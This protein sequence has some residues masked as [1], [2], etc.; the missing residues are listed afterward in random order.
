MVRGVG[1]KD[2]AELT[3]VSKPTVL[4]L[5][6]DL[7]RA[8]L[9]DQEVR[10]RD[11]PC[12]VIEADEI[13][14]YVK[15]KSL[16]TLPFGTHASDH[17]TWTAI[18]QD[19]RLIIAWYIGKRTARSAHIFMS[20]LKG[21]L[22]NRVQLVTDGLRLYID[23]VDLVF[24][25]DIDYVQNVNGLDRIIS[26]VPDLSRMST[27]YVERSN[28]TLRMGSRR[29]ARRCNGFSKSLR[30]HV[31]ATAIHFHYYN[32]ARIHQT[33][34]VTPAMACGLADEAWSIRDLVELLIQAERPNAWPFSPVGAGP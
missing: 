28:L 22:R 25:S 16:N 30:H 27:A 19:T 31:C 34:K 8:C 4:R 23:A 7:G 10:I 6:E 11:L 13:W 33:L 24:G 21:R 32:F 9:D 12:K 18:C 5:I 26:G 15:S 29:Y 14:Q 2:T 1:V 17:W 20:D 3:G